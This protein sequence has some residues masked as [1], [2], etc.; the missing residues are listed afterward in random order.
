MFSY[1]EEPP[2]A[3]AGPSPSSHWRWTASTSC[4]CRITPSSVGG[5]W[6][7]TRQN[8]MLF[9]F[10]IRHLF[11]ADWMK[12]SVTRVI[13]LCCRTLTTKWRK[14]TIFRLWNSIVIYQR[15]RWGGNT[16][17]SCDHCDCTAGEGIS[18]RLHSAVA[19]W[20]WLVTAG[21]G[22]AGYL[23]MGLQNLRLDDVNRFHGVN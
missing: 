14:G 10:L 18:A 20:K 13:S 8:K 1:L 21:V 16:A 2:P 7:T 22:P 23:L 17:P 19:V 15:T 9:L 4:R 3:E 11:S 12:Q 6:E 5:N